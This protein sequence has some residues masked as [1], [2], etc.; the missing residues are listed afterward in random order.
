L[1]S[2]GTFSP[3]A[4]LARPP[5]LGGRL[6][7]SACLWLVAILVIDFIACLLAYFALAIFGVYPLSPKSAGEKLEMTQAMIV[8]GAAVLQ[9]CL[10]A[11]AVREA[12]VYGQ[13]DARA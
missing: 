4:T 8:V 2:T 5:A 13:G 1:D 12:R 9:F 6:V 11:I 10:L 7:L 3:G